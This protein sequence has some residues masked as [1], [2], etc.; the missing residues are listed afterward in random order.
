MSDKS[1]YNTVDA[2]H[3]FAATYR[4]EVPYMITEGRLERIED[5]AAQIEKYEKW[6]PKWDII[7]IC[8]SAFASLALFGTGLLITNGV[9]SNPPIDIMLISW[10]RAITIGATFATVLTFILNWVHSIE[11]KEQYK[12]EANKLRDI[13]KKAKET[14]LNN[15]NT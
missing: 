5:I 2:Q 6:E 13:V 15:N 9:Q 1:S 4:A 8:M 3:R 12:V 10:I 14:V 7:K 11:R